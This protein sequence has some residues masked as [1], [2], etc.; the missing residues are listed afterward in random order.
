VSKKTRR[1]KR[2]ALAGATQHAYLDNGGVGLDPSSSSVLIFEGAHDVRPIVEVA[3]ARWKQ[4]ADAGTAVAA[5]G[6][7]TH[8]AEEAKLL[9]KWLDEANGDLEKSPDLPRLATFLFLLIPIRQREHLLGDLEEEFR[10]KLVPEYGQR[11]ARFYFYSQVVIELITALTKGVTGAVFGFAI[12][13]F[14]K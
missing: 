12:S 4:Q 2:R 6:Q 7:L 5:L 3:V 10:T 8:A 13:R 9:Q 11:W 1:K 14:T